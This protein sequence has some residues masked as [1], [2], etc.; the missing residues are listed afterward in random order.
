[1]DRPQPSAWG[2]QRRL[3][4]LM[5]RSWAPEAIERVSGIPAAEITTALCGR[6][7]IG[8]VLAGQV[9]AAYDMLW[10]KPPPEASQHDQDL[11]EAAQAHAR[12]HGWPLPLA[13]DDDLIDLP[14]GGPEPGWKPSGGA[15]I[16]SADLAEDIQFVRDHGGYRYASLTT[17]ATRLGVTRDAREKAQ[18]RTRRAGPEAESC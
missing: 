18:A 3:M 9:A 5:N 13:Y 14:D 2:T 17:V 15:T 1:M 4:A 12:R 11:A 8:R 6:E 16:H 10:D 7:T